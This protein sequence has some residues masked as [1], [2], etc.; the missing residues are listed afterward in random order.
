MR[1]QAPASMHGGMMGGA[2]RAV[3]ISMNIIAEPY[4]CVPQPIL[5]VQAPSELSSLLTTPFCVFS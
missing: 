2:V 4:K 5:C 1:A 3:P